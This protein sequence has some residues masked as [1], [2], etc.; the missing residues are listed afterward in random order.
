[1]KGKIKKLVRERGF[2][3]ISADDGTEVFFHRSDLE[4]IY[5]GLLEEGTSVEFDVE[6][7]ARSLR[8]VNITMGQDVGH[9]DFG[10][11]GAEPRS[12]RRFDVYARFDSIERKLDD[13]HGQLKAILEKLDHKDDRHLEE[14]PVETEPQ[15]TDD[16]EGFNF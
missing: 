15:D 4:G 6:R 1:L 12:G 2:G 16:E 10:R 14:M 3:F 11:E 13:I 7:G 5:F 8:A 9:D